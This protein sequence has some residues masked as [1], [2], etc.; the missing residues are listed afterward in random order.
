[1]VV[2]LYRTFAANLSHLI[3]VHLDTSAMSSNISSFLFD[4]DSVLFRFVLE[5]GLLLGQLLCLPGLSPQCRRSLKWLVLQP[6]PLH[7]SYVSLQTSWNCSS[8]NIK[9]KP[10]VSHLLSIVVQNLHT[11]P[12]NDMSGSPHHLVT[13]RPHHAV[14]VQGWGGFTRLLWFKMFASLQT[15]DNLNK[16]ES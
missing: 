11:I 6:T 9:T 4:I 1:M 2:A 5:P 3:V 7:F 12:D 10:T 16:R 14:L 8:D 15:S 13:M